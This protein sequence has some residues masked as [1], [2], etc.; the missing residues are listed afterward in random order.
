MSDGYDVARHDF[1]TIYYPGLVSIVRK[2]GWN[3]PQK[4]RTVFA[5]FYT[6]FDASFMC[7]LP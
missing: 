7:R 5:Q 1:Y 2:L 6:D 4:R 3:G